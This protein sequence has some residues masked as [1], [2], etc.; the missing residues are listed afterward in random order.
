MRKNRTMTQRALILTAATLGVTI[1]ALAQTT[2]TWA[3]GGVQDAGGTWDTTTANWTSGGPNIAWPNNASPGDNALFGNA[4]AT[5]TV[6][7]SGTIN[8]NAIIFNDTDTGFDSF[9][10]LTSGT[11][12][13]VGSALIDPRGNNNYRIDSTITGSSG[14]VVDTTSGSRNSSSETRLAGNN[15][16]TGITTVRDSVLALYHANALGATGSGN[17]TILEAGGGVAYA[18]NVTTTYA[19][20]DIL[21][22]GGGNIR[23]ANGDS[24]AGGN[25]TLNRATAFGNVHDVGFDIRDNN[26]TVVWNG[27][28]T[29]TSSDNS[30]T[31][32]RI[33]LSTASRTNSKLT[34]NGII[35]DGQR[36]D[37]TT[38]QTRLLITGNSLEN[39]AVELAGSNSFTGEV[40]LRNGAT[41]LL[42]HNNALGTTAG[43]LNIGDGGGGGTTMRVL[44]TGAYTIGDNIAFQNASGGAYTAIVGGSHTSGTS[45]YTGGITWGDDVASTYRLTAAPGGTVVFSGVINDGTRTKGLEIVG[46]GTVVMA[47][48]NT[49]DG[50]TSIASGTTLRRARHHQ[51]H[52]QQRHT[53]LQPQ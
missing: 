6:T 41:L 30:Q 13:L 50:A 53:H 31:T 19:N 17:T 24:T 2:Y 9:W 29:T 49:Y 28:L 21:N 4:T 39:S 11:L 32:A 42:S 3:P 36:A 7:L 34:I 15:T 51:R 35:S 46:G 47:N 40:T 18:N 1:P 8:A 16:Y 44:T 43:S 45:T 14:L 27:N 25:Y 10:R 37:L 22:Q 52:H 12:N 26:R 20:E 23:F 33:L 5:R 38:M 48:N